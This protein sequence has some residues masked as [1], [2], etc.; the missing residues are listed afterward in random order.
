MT[1]ACQRVIE[2]I[3]R[4]IMTHPDSIDRIDTTA[5]LSLPGTCHPLR[6]WRM[7]QGLSL[8]QAADKVGTTRQVWHNWETGK[9]RPRPR[10]MARLRQVTGGKVNADVFYPETDAA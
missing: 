8:A 9:R 10:Y 1:G 2:T 6:A 4:T 5:A 7:A 3:T